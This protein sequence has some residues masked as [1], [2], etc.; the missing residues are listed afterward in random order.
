MV[1]SRRA[2]T[3][4]YFPDLLLPVFLSPQWATAT[5]LFCRRPS[6]TSRNFWFSLLW[7]HCSFPLGPDAHTTLCVLLKCGVSVSPSPVKVLQSN[8]ARLQS[9]ILW[10]SSVCCW[11]PQLGSLMLDSEPS[12]QCV[13]FCG[14]TVLQFVSHP[15]SS[16]GIWF[17]CYCSPPTISLKLLLCLWIWGMFFGEFQCLPVDDCSAVSCDSG[18]LTRGSERTSFY[19]SILN[20]SLLDFLKLSPFHR[21]TPTWSN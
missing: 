8:P 18:V 4:E 12:L 6:N 5:P 10:D 16:Y 7:G 2:H 13:D 9:L 3:K 17:Y 15:P 19:S 1:D 11:T 21:H 14:I 20:Q